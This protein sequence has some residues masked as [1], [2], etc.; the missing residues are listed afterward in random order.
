MEVNDMMILLA[1]QHCVNHM[2]DLRRRHPDAKCLRICFG[3]AVP[4]IDDGV[5]MEVFDWNSLVIELVQAC[6]TLFGKCSLSEKTI[7]KKQILQAIQDDPLGVT[8]AV[9]VCLHNKNLGYYSIL[10]DEKAMIIEIVPEDKSSAPS[11]DLII[12]FTAEHYGVTAADLL[13]PSRNKAVKQGRQTAIFLV[14]KITT[15]SPTQ[16][17]E[18]FGIGNVALVMRALRSV[19]DSVSS[20]DEDQ[21]DHIRAITKKIDDTFTDKECS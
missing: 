20:G 11:F 5:Y 1:V 19:E 17:A 21:I 6:R 8:V 10:W 15:L 4:A 14:K 16:I 13:R 2:S 18:K 9:M 7:L 12:A 3:E